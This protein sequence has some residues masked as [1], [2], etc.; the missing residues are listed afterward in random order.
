MN[1][2]QTSVQ[3]SDQLLICNNLDLAEVTQQLRHEHQ[4]S[5]VGDS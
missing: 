4:E 5:E 3:Y 2:L 1:Q